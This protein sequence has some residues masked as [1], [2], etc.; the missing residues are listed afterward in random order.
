MSEIEEER[1]L[2][3]VAITRARN[4]LVLTRS[5]EAVRGERRALR[6][7]SRFLV[8]LQGCGLVEEAIDDLPQRDAVEVTEDHA[9]LME[10]LAQLGVNLGKPKS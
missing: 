4:H 6:L 7:P 5:N 10:R 2:L 3:Y 1:R 9:A 8:D